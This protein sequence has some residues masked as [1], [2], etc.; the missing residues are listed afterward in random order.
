MSFFSLLVAGVSIGIGAR[1]IQSIVCDG[2]VIGRGAVVSRGCVLSYGVVVGEGVVLPEYSRI[3]VRQ[4][5][6]AE[7][8]NTRV[9]VVCVCY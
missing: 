5:R 9:S 1:V 7:K 4:V 3:S 2:V 6:K 8:F